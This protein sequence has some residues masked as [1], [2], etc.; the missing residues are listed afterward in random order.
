MIRKELAKK[1]VDSSLSLLVPAQFSSS[2]VALVWG[3]V[4]DSLK[5]ISK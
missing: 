4:G 5:L 1:L 3:D 2:N